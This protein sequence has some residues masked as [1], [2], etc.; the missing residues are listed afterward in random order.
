MVLDP[1]FWLFL[2]VGPVVFHALPERGRYAW[3]AAASLA[4]MLHLSPVSAA[5]AGSCSVAAFFA[6]RRAAADEVRRKAIVR[7]GIAVLV[8]LLVVWKYTPDAARALDDESWFAQIAYPVGMSF[9]V[10]RLIHYVIEVSRGNIADRSLSTF[11]AWI[12]LVPIYTA[13]PIEQYDHFLAHRARVTRQDI[14]VGLLRIGHGVGKKLI[15]ADAFLGAGLLQHGMAEFIEE[16]PE[17]S[18]L[19]IWL[20]L[21]GFFAW[22]YIDFSAYSDLAIGGSR[23]FGFRIAENF[24]WPM[25][26]SN[27]REFWRRWHMTLAQ[28]TQR[29]VYMPIIAR[30][31]NP[32]LA[33]YGTFMV[34]GLWH[35]A[36]LSYIA[37]ALYHA[38]GVAVA[39]TFARLRR[40][41]KWGPGP[42]VLRHWGIPLTLAYASGSAIFSGTSGL[43]TDALLTLL[44]Y[45][46]GLA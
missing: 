5:I 3:L 28:W 19:E 34:M 9:Y 14:L 26:A 45:A 6:A 1:Y 35:A 31:R 2:L 43:G 21:F 27:M 39:L 16:L 25:V 33:V 20:Y 42:P 30:T 13:G 40:Q 23:L 12:M 7:G 4:Y 41:R 37:W 44:S 11:L 15:I 17:Q 38:T 29:Y 36:D 46:L 18:L 22:G 10:F 24:D 8:A 32:Y